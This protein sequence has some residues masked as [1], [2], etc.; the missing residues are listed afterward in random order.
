[1][2]SFKNSIGF[3]LF[4]IELLLVFVFEFVLIVELSSISFNLGAIFGESYFPFDLFGTGILF[5][6]VLLPLSLLLLF[7]LYIL[8]TLL[9]LLTLR[10]KL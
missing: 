4:E 2:K 5:K 6:A 7:G 3:S 10:L 9:L 8:K 1:L